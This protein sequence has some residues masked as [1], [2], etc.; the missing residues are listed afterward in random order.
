MAS[1]FLTFLEQNQPL[2]VNSWANKHTFSS[3]FMNRSN[4]DQKL[5]LVNPSTCQTNSGCF[6]K[7][8]I[9]NF[10]NNSTL[11]EKSFYVVKECYFETNK[12]VIV[13]LDINKND[14]Y[15]LRFSSAVIILR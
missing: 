7:N 4:K 11:K 15:K 10:F 8:K 14:L 6:E 1:T 12:L 2:T 5:F 13:Y 3:K 9:S